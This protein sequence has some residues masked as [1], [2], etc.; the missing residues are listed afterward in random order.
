ME[1]FYLVRYC[2][3]LN[4]C[5]SKI[6]HCIEQMSLRHIDVLTINGG[7][8]TG[9]KLGGRGKEEGRGSRRQKGGKRRK[10]KKRWE[11][12]GGKRNRGRSGSKGDISV[13]KQ[14]LMLPQQ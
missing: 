11:G 5:L 2:I 1:T 13:T 9:K 3:V 12:E 10:M 14:T 4:Q 6:L 8:G 7:G